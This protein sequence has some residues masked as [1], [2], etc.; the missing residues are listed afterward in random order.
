MNRP[1]RLFLICLFGFAGWVTFKIMLP[2]AT[3][4]QLNLTPEEYADG[5]KRRAAVTRKI[6]PS[7]KDSVSEAG[8]DWGA[9]VFLR[10]FKEE[11]VLELWMMKDDQFA[12]FQSYPIA[13][14][15]G[16]LGP[17]LAEGDRQVP[18]GFYYVTPNAMNPAS[19]FH[20]S[21]NI[22]YPNKYDL[23]HDRTGS[24]IMVHG[25]N[26]SIGCLAMSDEKIE[27]IYT[28]CDTAFHHGQKFFRIHLFPFR[29]TPEKMEAH[30]DHEWYEFWQNLKT[31]YDWFEEK[32]TPPDVTVKEKSYHFQRAT[33]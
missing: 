19:D 10:A 29:M 22:G 21:F 31:G 30:Q 26:V 8:F 17:K 24:F 9:P 20:L 3:A 12:L 4:D 33:P 13:A 11:K 14:A 16:E 1:A 28:L 18:E 25:S 2:G 23:A 15:S 7:L 27:E 32:K 5:S 6:T